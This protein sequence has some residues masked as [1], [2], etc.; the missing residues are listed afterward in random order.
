MSR[1]QEQEKQ[2]SAAAAPAQTPQTQETHNRTASQEESQDQKP[3]ALPA[4]EGPSETLQTLDIS[5]NEKITLDH[6]GPLVINSDGTL[7]RIA[8]WAEMSALERERTVRILGRRNQIR[9]EGL[10]NDS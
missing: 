5:T 9:R 7:S 10:K 8:N 4:P 6:L 1:A 3:L 2:S